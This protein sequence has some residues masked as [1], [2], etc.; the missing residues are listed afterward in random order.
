M[1]ERSTVEG[2]QNS[3]ERLTKKWWLY[4]MLLLLFALPIYASKDYDPRN[5]LGVVKQALLDPLIYS[6]PAL[7]P[8][9]KLLPI[10]LILAVM[11]FGNRARRLYNGYV[12]L[13]YLAL[14]LFQNAAFTD[15]YGF[16]LITG[17]IAAV[18]IVA[19]VW[20][21]ESIAEKN[22]FAPRKRSLWRWWIAPLAALALLAPVDASSLT[23]DF[24][25][26]N[27][28]AN[29]AGLTYCMMTPVTL[30]VLILFY[31]T[32]NQVVLRI[33]SF[34]GFIFGIINEVMWFAI[35]PAGWWMGVLHIPLLVIAVYGF[36]LGHRALPE[37]GW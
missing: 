5:S 30:A 4:L 15:G 2:I 7:M 26:V 22:D 27:L 29:E 21:W 23:P 10:V 3:L 13:L 9:A 16:V 18:L 8:I 17:N 25:L 12:A 34:V 11:F 19:L 33:S 20:L 35:L 32:I 28:L 37:R 24:C 1:S 14:A 36:V 6:Y 31:P